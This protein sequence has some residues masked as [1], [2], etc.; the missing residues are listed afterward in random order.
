MTKTIEVP[1]RA[2]ARHEEQF[3]LH[4]ARHLRDVPR[5]LRR[6]LVGDVCQHLA[7]R[8]PTATGAQLWSQVGSPG[9]YARELRTE[10]GLGPERR[11]PWARWIVVPRWKR[12][13]TVTAVVTL[14]A[15]I[16]AAVQLDHRSVAPPVHIDNLGAGATFVGSRPFEGI[17]MSSA[18]DQH[19]YHVTYEAGR[20]LQ[21][22]LNL[23]P[24][25]PMRLESV[26]FGT[27]PDS[28]I[29]LDGIAMPRFDSLDMPFQRLHPVAVGPAGIWIRLRFHFADCE[30]FSAY[31]SLTW[32]SVSVTYSADG[33]TR[34]EGVELGA[35]LTVTSPP[36]SA[37]PARG[38]KG[39]A[40]FRS[41]GG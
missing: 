29:V 32:D 23:S 31:A 11:N 18:L 3:T 4:V 41:P 7:E 28:L 38:Q 19:E 16:V 10:H 6:E 35:A 20:E 5:A 14:V 24:D 12:V 40:G 1:S 9:A 34:H 37:C 30:R 33:R 2:L 22:L 15:L 8:P 21:L 27:P 25:R 13:S 17:S 26:R 39:G 36:D